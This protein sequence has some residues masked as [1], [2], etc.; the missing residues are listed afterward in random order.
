MHNTAEWAYDAVPLFTA[1][2]VA[3]TESHGI[4]VG[5]SNM[6]ASLKRGLG[7]VRRVTAFSAI[8]AP[9]V[10]FGLGAIALPMTVG[11][12]IAW[13]RMLNQEH[14]GLSLSSRAEAL[15]LLGK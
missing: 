6:E 12:R 11:S 8:G 1:V 13:S 4:L 9:L 14:L 15:R 3:V 2:F 5:R 7:R 10:A